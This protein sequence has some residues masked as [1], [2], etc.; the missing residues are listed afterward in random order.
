[1]NNIHQPEFKR[2]LSNVTSKTWSQPIEKVEWNN[3]SSTITNNT[4]YLLKSKEPCN[5]STSL[6]LHFEAPF[7]IK[8]T[9]GFNKI[10]KI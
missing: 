8:V 1:M 2:L 7:R 5:S 6:L 4:E 3:T 9:L 10:K